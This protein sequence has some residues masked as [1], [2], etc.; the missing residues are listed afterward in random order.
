MPALRAGTEPVCAESSGTVRFREPSS[1]SPSSDARSSIRRSTTW[2]QL[3]VTLSI[4]LLL[5]LTACGG[6]DEPPAATQSSTPGTETSSTAE[7]DPEAAAQ[8]AREAQVDAVL[9]GLDRRRQIAQLFVVGVPVNNPSG[10]AVPLIQETGV[11]GIFLHGR[12]AMA[13]TDL[14]AATA[15]WP[16]LTPGLRPWVA[17]DQEGGEVQTLSGPGFD[18]LPPAVEQGALPPDQLAAVADGLGASLASAGINLDLAPVVDVVPAGTEQRNEPIGV[19]G[20]QYGSTAAAVVPAAGA[21]VD[22]LAAHGV[23]ATIK[24]FPGLGRVE[25][26]TDDVSGVTDT[27]TTR[28]DEQVAAFGTLA[29]S[30]SAPFVMTSSATYT[31]ID[32]TAPAAFSPVVVTDL[33]RGQLGFDG[34]VISDDLGAAEAV[35]DIRPG[36]RAVRFL[37]AGGTLVL[38]VT[39]AVLPAMIDGVLARAEAD[40]AFSAQVDAAV[41]TALLAKAERGLLG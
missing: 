3:T 19:F 18:E 2:R 21:V 35:Q 33:L 14:A 5:A 12:S 1:R 36:D 10:A 26:N 11:G 30:A 8:A 28:D 15:G 23:T 40:P 27:V 9:G 13:A 6:G 34:V 38:T 31:L 37:A 39:A 32:P 22:G 29:G 4:L 7:P 16:E 24:H 17:V 25:G 41:R 20:R